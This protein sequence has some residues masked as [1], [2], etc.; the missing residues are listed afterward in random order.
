MK[1]KKKKKLKQKLSITIDE[2][3]IRRIKKLLKK[4]NF[5]SLSHIV[6]F[7]IIKLLKEGENKKYSG[8]L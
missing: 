5:R 8:L 4:E 1:R 3:N 7:A 6:E 2:N